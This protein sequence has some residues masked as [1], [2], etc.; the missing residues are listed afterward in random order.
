MSGVG[1][2]GLENVAFMQSLE[3]ESIC[4][5]SPG[6]QKCESRGTATS[7]VAQELQVRPMV[8]RAEFHEVWTLTYNQN[9]ENPWAVCS[10]CL[11]NADSRLDPRSTEPECLASGVQKSA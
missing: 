3:G 9:L 10:G 8:I 1:V 6:R 5:G 2:G 11:F 7:G 4:Q